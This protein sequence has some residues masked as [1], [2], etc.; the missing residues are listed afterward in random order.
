MDSM[1]GPE[2]EA[3]AAAIGM[4][5][6]RVPGPQAVRQH[7]AKQFAQGQDSHQ[8]G[9]QSYNFHRLEQHSHD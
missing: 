5:Y 8:D 4:E 1:R 3:A 6:M 2:V 7:T 9:L